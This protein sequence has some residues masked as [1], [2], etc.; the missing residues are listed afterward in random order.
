MLYYGARGKGV[1]S[2]VWIAKPDEKLLSYIL[3]V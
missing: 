3:F 2:V 1:F